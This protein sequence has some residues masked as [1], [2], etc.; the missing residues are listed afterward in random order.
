M[1]LEFAIQQGVTHENGKLSFFDPG[2]SI[3]Q[4]RDHPIVKGKGILINQ[5]WYNSFGWAEVSE[6]PC[7]RSIRLLAKWDIFDLD[8]NGK[9]RHLLQNERVP[10][11]RR[12]CALLVINALAKGEKDLLRG[13]YVACFD[14]KD[15]MHPFIGFP[16]TDGYSIETTYGMGIVGVGIA[17]EEK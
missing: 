9:S 6:N 4:M 16:E 17:A 7:K 3:I 5:D 8:F 11:L 2:M 15:Q 13:C 12:V 14:M 1:T 10:R